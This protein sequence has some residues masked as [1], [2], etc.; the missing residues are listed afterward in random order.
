M[1]NYTYDVV[2]F[3]RYQW[4]QVCISDYTRHQWILLGTGI[5]NSSNYTYLKYTEQD[6]AVTTIIIIIIL[7][8][9]YSICTQFEGLNNRYMINRIKLDLYVFFKCRSDIWRSGSSYSDYVGHYC[10]S[11]ICY[12]RK[13]QKLKLTQNIYYTPDEL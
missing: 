4:T 11:I 9:N 5:L 10:G 7:L 13:H 6:L 12:R 1:Y 3:I 8:K 2:G